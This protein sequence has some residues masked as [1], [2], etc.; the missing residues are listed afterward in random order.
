MSEPT[1]AVVIAAHNA[2]RTLAKC[3]ESV[4]DMDYPSEKLEV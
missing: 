2:E 1:V 3:I 4:L